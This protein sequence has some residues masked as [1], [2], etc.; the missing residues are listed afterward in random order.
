MNSY[1]H[2]NS[3][4]VQEKTIELLGGWSPLSCKDK[5]KKRN[6]FLKNQILLS[7]DQK[8]ELQMTPALEK[9]GPVA[10]TSSR[11]VQRQSQRNSEE[12]ER[13]QEQ[14][15]KGQ[16]QSQLAQTLPTR[17][18]DSQNEALSHEKCV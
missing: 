4:L 18:Q 8:R 17:L 14:S 11:S 16:R 9:E 13:P 5:V 12:T 7:V 15:S 6:N 10:S 1:L 2:I 3:F